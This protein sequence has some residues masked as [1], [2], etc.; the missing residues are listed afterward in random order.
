[1][2]LPEG[3][4][5]NEPG[6]R[7]IRRCRL[8]AGGI[9]T[10]A[11]QA[12]VTHFDPVFVDDFS[13]LNPFSPDAANKPIALYLRSGNEATFPLDAVVWKRSL[14]RSSLR[15]DDSWADATR[16]L[17]STEV[18]LG[19][20]D[21]KDIA[22]R[23]RPADTDGQGLRPR[24]VRDTSWYVW[25]QGFHSRGADGIYYCQL[26]SRR[27]NRN[28]LVRVR[29]RPELGKNT[30]GLPSAEFEVEAE[31]VWPL[32]RGR[33]VGAFQIGSSGLYCL[34]PHVP[35]DLAKVMTRN[36]LI[37]RAPHLYDYL[38]QHQDRLLHRSAYDLKLTDDTP[39][40]IQGTSWRYLRPEVNLVVCRY[41]YPDKRPPAAVAPPT[42]HSELGR[43][44]TI[45]PNNKLNFVACGSIQEADY[46]CAF[47][48]SSRAQD[49]IARLASSTTISPGVMNSLP[50]PR[51]DRTNSLYCEL[52]RL[53][54]VCREEPSSWVQH[55]SEITSVVDQIAGNSREA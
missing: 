23:W 11:V 13:S 14:P 6:G 55:R 30:K 37:S 21:P 3:I 41:I 36:Q 5:L 7:A 35:E 29:T 15:A 8:E 2:L 20:I 19:P 48:N 45:Y 9:Y 16:T 52:A 47:V 10:G 26:T 38:E 53:G 24:S 28:G 51:Y 43:S 50:I 39:W 33:D 34:L 17:S 4:L 25:G 54:R 1:M 22:S 42:A 49:L 12:N 40:G 18:R 27:P 44:T 32:V 31:F 46:L